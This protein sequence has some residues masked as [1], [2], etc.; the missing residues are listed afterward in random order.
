MACFISAAMMIG[1]E[2][3]R[4]RDERSEKMVLGQG[5]D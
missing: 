5:R 4:S 3:A 2:D 1:D